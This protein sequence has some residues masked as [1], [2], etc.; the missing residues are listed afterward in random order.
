MHPSVIPKADNVQQPSSKRK[1][2]EL[3]AAAPNKKV[4]V[5]AEKVGTGDGGGTVLGLTQ[6]QVDSLIID[7][8][9]EDMQ[10]LCVLNSRPLSA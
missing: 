10:S 1:V 4:L 7:F 9:I 8:V 5:T 2:D 6:A 3:C